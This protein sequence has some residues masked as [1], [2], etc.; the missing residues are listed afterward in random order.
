MFGF[1]G[2]MITVGAHAVGVATH[3][4]PAIND[5]ALTEVYLTQPAVMVDASFG[6]FQFSGMVNFEGLTLRRGELNAGVYG[7]GYVDRRHPHTYL[8]EAI[9]TLQPATLRER[10]SISAG[11]GFAPFGTDDPMVRHFVKYP[12]NHHL[13]QILE[14]LVVIGAARLGPM[15]A[16]AGLFNGTE[17]TAPDDFG[18]GDAFGD[19]WSARLSVLPLPWLELQA[20]YADVVS[21]ENAAGQ[22]LDHEM[23]NVSAR[24]QRRVANHDLYLLIERGKTTEGKDAFDY[25]F[26]ETMLA[27]AAVQRAA[28]QLAARFERT[29]RPEEE[30]Q[31]DL[32]RS[33]RPHTDNSIL[34]TTR[35]TSAS[36]QVSHI[37]NRKGVRIQPFVE[38]GR[39]H[40]KALDEFP[41]LTP[42]N[43]YGADRLWSFSI[44]MRSSLGIWHDR[45]GRYGAARVSSSQH[46]H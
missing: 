4:T 21:P 17:P 10:A 1:L 14:R 9:L 40:V 30:R 45:M 24:V 6:P 8:H 25:F 13:S 39:Q 43:I 35:W 42:E 18:D 41:V 22:G 27:E 37:I 44:G 19:S 11:R 32:F 46:H 36:I 5:R 16:E 31:L 7:E 20:S 12:A 3:A 33:V 34:G 38:I 28:W 26:Y 23:W 15:I 2:Q 29:V